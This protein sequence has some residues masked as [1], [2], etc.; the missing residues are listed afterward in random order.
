VGARE[1]SYMFGQ[2]K[3]IA[4]EFTGVMTGKGPAFG[5]SL[6]RTEATGYGCVYMVAHMLAVKKN[7]LEGKTAVVSGSGNVAQY[8]A[9]KL[10]E[11]GVTLLTLSDSSGFIHDP[12]GISKEKLEFVKDLKNV[13]RD[14]ISR[15]ADEF[16]A[17]YFPGQRPWNVPVDLA[18]PCATHNELNGSDA[19]NLI[20]NGC[21]AVAEGAN[22]PTDQ[23]GIKIFHDAKI[24]YAPSKAANAG[25]VAV[26]ALEMAQNSMHLSWTR[27]EVDRRLHKIMSNIHDTCMEYGA[28][29][30]YVNYRK[31]ANIAGFIKV[32][33]AMLACGVL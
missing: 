15:Y 27:E 9:E 23:E 29:G 21:I 17:E 32:A 19:A 16:D 14:R 2:Y 28:E 31:G 22:M 30:D 6:I 13:K 25:G 3:R 20:K 33:D 24:M 8:T 4:N 12:E 18:F 7:A 10:I 26:S 11:N 5:G 1:I